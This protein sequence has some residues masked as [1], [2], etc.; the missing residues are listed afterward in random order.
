MD[1]T[2]VLKENIVKNLCWI[3]GDKCI[4]RVSFLSPICTLNESCYECM[5][6]KDFK[7]GFITLLVLS[8][9]NFVDGII[10][11]QVEEGVEQKT[12]GIEQEIESDIAD[13]LKKLLSEV[14]D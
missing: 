4:Y 14:L 6:F 7:K 11:E 5:A 10:A 8:E 2:S 3:N 12:A 9:T 1:T 13:L